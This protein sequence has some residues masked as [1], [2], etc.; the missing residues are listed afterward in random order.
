MPD[1]TARYETEFALAVGA[2][3]AIAFG[4]ARHALVAILTA[5]GLR[6]GDEIILSPL[7]CKVVPLALFSL[8][9]RPVYTDISEATLNLDPARV[10]AAISPA[11]RAILFQQTYGHAGGIDQVAALA[12]QHGLLLVEDCAQCMPM[13]DDNY[14][15][16]QHGSCA[17]FSNNPG[18]PLP[19]ASGGM[20]VTRDAALAVAIRALRD[21]LPRRGLRGGIGLYAEAW[22]H[23]HVLRP[24]LYWLLFDLHRRTSGNATPESLQ[25]DIADEITGCAFRP[26]NRQLRLGR[27]WMRKIPALA[28]QR[29]A[30]CNE[31]AHALESTPGITRPLD[32]GSAPLYYYPVLIERKPELLQRARRQR[33][34]II[35][36]PIAAPVYPLED[37][38]AMAMF[39]YRPGDCPVAESVATRLV[40]L[41]THE[42]I[43]ER[44]RNKVIALLKAHVMA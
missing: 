39:G 35:P 11:T 6:A 43:T 29:R 1:R 34:E 20:A 12:D 2:D 3:H 22:L 44:V 31:Y 4:F 37:I 26:S 16:G 25:Q 30:C 27:Q 9:L 19:A 33:V 10:Q 23:R 5:A 28:E 38:Q 14:Q 13:R 17:I 32:A 41:P 18:K 7:T 40:G 21:Q 8:G 15:P 42:K 36:W 24:S